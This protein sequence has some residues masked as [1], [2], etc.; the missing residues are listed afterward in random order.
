MATD[1]VLT[2]RRV[3]VFLIFCEGV[4]YRRGVVVKA[5]DCRIVE[6]E[7]EHWSHYYVHFQ[8]IPLAKVWTPLSFQRLG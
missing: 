1:W 8:K 4:G 6:R 3:N 5:I 7:F 2:P